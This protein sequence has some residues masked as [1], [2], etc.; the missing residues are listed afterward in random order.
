MFFFSDGEH[1]WQ[2]L[3]KLVPN[4]NGAL[5][6]AGLSSYVW[7]DFK[8]GDYWACAITKRVANSLDRAH[9]GKYFAAPYLGIAMRTPAWSRQFTRGAMLPPRFTFVPHAEQNANETYYP[10]RHN[11]AWQTLPFASFAVS[12][13]S[14]ASSHPSETIVHSSFP[15]SVQE[16][17]TTAFGSWSLSNRKSREF[18]Q[19]NCDWPNSNRSQVMP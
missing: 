12:Y 3:A 4:P 1:S 8:R 19:N 17:S 9:R 18:R 6:L 10:E 13:C 15:V 2:Q 14:S 11:W 5:R 7:D 16:E